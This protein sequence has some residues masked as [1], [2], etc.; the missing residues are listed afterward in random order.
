MTR[1]LRDES[2]LSTAEEYAQIS[3]LATGD[4]RHIEL[5][6]VTGAIDRL[7][8]ASRAHSASRA[9]QQGT[10]LHNQRRIDTLSEQ[11]ETIEALT[12]TP[13]DHCD[14]AAIGAAVI[15]IPR[16]RSETTIAGVTYQA[17]R[18][19][20]G[21]SLDIDGTG[22]HQWIDNDRLRP[23]DE[24]RGLGRSILT[25]PDNLN[26]AVD[27]PRSDIDN[28]QR[29]LA[30]EQARPIPEQFPRQGE[31]DTA[32]TRRDELTEQLNPREPRT[33]DSTGAPAVDDTGGGVAHPI[34]GDRTPT[35]SERYE[36]AGAYRRHNPDTTPNW[37][38]RAKGADAWVAAVNA[39]SVDPNRSATKTQAIG[40]Y[41]GVMLTARH[42]GGAVHI[43][44]QR[45]HDRFN[46]LTVD[47]GS[48][49][50]PTI[51]TWLTSQHQAASDEYDTLRG[52]TDIAAA[53]KTPSADRTGG[54]ER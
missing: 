32:R 13:R 21:I 8:R 12:P 11:I 43:A 3:A 17:S 19:Y 40:Q 45:H 31:L 30:A 26:R 53:T 10:L 1:N 50:R 37:G 49:D 41:H 54:L 27:R 25:D 5:A 24:G 20:E 33:V 14:P 34:Y 46:A 9:S 35:T 16:G 28:L 15:A 38:N 4:Q 52:A 22:I 42:D 39:W 29:Q 7:E 47:A 18:G 23:A 6:S 36:W 51:E 2:V 44:P 48:L